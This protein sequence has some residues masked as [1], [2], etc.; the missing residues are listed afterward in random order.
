MLFTNFL[1]HIFFLS[2]FALTDTG[3]AQDIRE[4]ERIIFVLL[5]HFHPLINIHTF[6]CSFA[7][8]MASF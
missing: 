3:N 6:I 5:Y 7:F 2:G 4:R 8:E 1:L